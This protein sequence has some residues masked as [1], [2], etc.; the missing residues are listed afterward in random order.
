RDDV[1]LR[2]WLSVGQDALEE[3]IDPLITSI[4]EQAVRAANVEFE[5]YVSLKESAIESHCEEVKRLESK[6]EDLNDQL[7]TAADRAASLEVLEEQDA[8]EAALTSHRSELEELLEAEQNGFS[9]KQA[10]I[11][12]RHSIEVRCEPLGAAYF[13]YEKG[14]V[15]LTL[16][17][18]TA[19]TQLRV[20]FGRGVGVMEPVCCCRCG[21][22]LSAEN[23]LS[24][25]Q[26]DVVGMCCSE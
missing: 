2:N 8:V 23:P 14:D 1:T 24:V 19:E 4:R 7:T 17:E 11:R 12:S 25:V 13:E 26:G 21:T 18:D 16:G 5:E 3:A 10:A 22:Q 20:A 6:L 15:V 9:D